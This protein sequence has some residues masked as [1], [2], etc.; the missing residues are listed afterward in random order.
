MKQGGGKARGCSPR[1]RPPRSVATRALSSPLEESDQERS[2]TG[3]W[4]MKVVKSL[5]FIGLSCGI[6]TVS[7]IKPQNQVTMLQSQTSLHQPT[8]NCVLKE[9][10]RRPFK[11]SR[12]Q[13]DS[14]FVWGCPWLPPCFRGSVYCTDEYMAFFIKSA[15]IAS[16]EPGRHSYP[17]TH[18][19]YK[20]PQWA[21]RD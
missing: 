17:S 16:A 7:W 9:G 11:C 5:H 20:F 10:R 6:C 12:L 1:A 4:E 2:E 15:M 13:L 19:S 18:T 21:R 3:S 14:A 8:E